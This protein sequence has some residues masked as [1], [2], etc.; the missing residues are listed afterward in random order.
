[1]LLA[2]GDP[3]GSYAR[4]VVEIVGAGG[5]VLAVHPAPKGEVG[6][7][8]WEVTGPVCVLTAWDPG[9]E[10]PGEMENRRRQAAL[11]AV[12]RPLARALWPALG[13]DPLTGHREEGVAV[14]GVSEADVVSLG[15]RYRQDAVF[16]WTPAA[17]TILACAGGRRVVGG[18]SLGRPEPG[19]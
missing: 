12:L 2:P 13:V 6:T 15:G 18:W 16:V 4:T 8:P 11:E 10:R 17:W 9:D 19:G 7:W 5:R 3:W 1:M 14:C